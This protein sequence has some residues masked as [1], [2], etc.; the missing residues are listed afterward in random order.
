MNPD[1]IAAKRF[2]AQLEAK[3]MSTLKPIDNGGYEITGLGLT[4][5]ADGANGQSG[6]PCYA[7][8][9]HGPTLD[10]LAD[11]GHPG[12]WW[13]LACDIHGIPFIQHETDYAP[14]AYISTTSYEVSGKAVNDPDRYLD[15]AS[16]PFIVVPGHFI[17]SVPGIVL[18]CK[19]EVEHAGKIVPAMAGDKGPAW[20]EFSLF[21]CQQFDPTATA[22]GT[23][24]S[25]GV[26]VRIWPG[27]QFDP[28]WPLQ[29]S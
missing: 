21:L 10:V 4:A 28:R 15:A 27:V 24:I 18:G 2:V 17:K 7:P 1:L 9:G 22:H 19:C 20:G 6:L 11:A 14:G 25:S 23:S 13:G 12:N 29:H 5:D 26:T 16:V 3:P 8:R